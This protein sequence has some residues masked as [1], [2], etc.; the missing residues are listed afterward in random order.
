MYCGGNAIFIEGLVSLR[1]GVVALVC[2]FRVYPSFRAILRRNGG[3]TPRLWRDSVVIAIMKLV[4]NRVRRDV[5]R[6]SISG[7]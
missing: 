2:I 7:C 3:E 5:V 6:G 4:C 1:I